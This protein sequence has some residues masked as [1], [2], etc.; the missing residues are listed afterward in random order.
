M[1]DCSDTLEL[2]RRIRVHAVRMTAYANASHI[3]T[4]LSMADILAVLYGKIL[5][6]DPKKPDLPERDRLILSKG[7][8]AAALYAV[9]AER[10]FFP[11]DWLRRYCDDDQ[12]LA[13]HVSHVGV[14]GVEASTGSLG[15]GLSL[16]AGIALAAQADSSSAHTYVVLSDGELDEGSSWEAI[17][18]AGHLQLVGLTAI[19]DANGIQS[20]GSVSEVLDLEP[21]ADKWRTCG[22]AVLDIDGH[23][24]VALREALSTTDS[25]PHPRVVIARTVK[26]KGVSFME[27][28][29]EW[30]YRSPSGDNLNR[31]LAELERSR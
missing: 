31:A 12:P 23:D 2:A 1:F 16:A 30:H 19:V 29:L 8:G 28:R 14:P 15:H 24:H 18:L 10:G 13:G 26:G 7:H 21:L 4:N 25:S 22:W 5:Q 17:M 20:F 3:G 6:V 9:L 11:T 27:N